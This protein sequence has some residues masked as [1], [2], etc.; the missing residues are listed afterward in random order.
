L[1]RPP[2]TEALLPLASLRNPPLTEASSA[3]AA[4]FVPPLTAARSPLATFSCTPLTDDT[5]PLASF[6]SPPATVAW[7]ALASLVAPPVTEAKGPVS[8]LSVPATSPPNCDQACP[9]PT[10]RL[11]EPVRI[12]FGGGSGGEPG[13]G[14]RS[15]RCVSLYP[16]IRLPSPFTGPSVAPAPE[17]ICTFTPVKRRV[18]PSSETRRGGRRSHDIEGFL[19]EERRAHF[20]TAREDTPREFTLRAAEVA[21]PRGRTASRAAEIRTRTA[22]PR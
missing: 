17:T 15:T 13:G 20:T 22:H 7:L 3:L 4:L 11:W 12:G 16:M 10:T 8:A 14:R 1:S 21:L 19:P 18:R 9:G 6:E 5:P 2:L